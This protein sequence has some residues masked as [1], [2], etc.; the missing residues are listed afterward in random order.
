MTQSVTLS[1]TKQEEDD[2]I[3]V[4][5]KF[6]GRSNKSGMVRYWTMKAKEEQSKNQ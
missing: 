3:E 5:E 2:L 6:F 1:L 4:S